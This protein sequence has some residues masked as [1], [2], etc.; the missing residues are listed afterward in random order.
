MIDDSQNPE[1]SADRFVCAERL[2][3]RMLPDE[4]RYTEVGENFRYYLTWREKLFAGFIVINGALAIAFTWV[5]DRYPTLTFLLPIGGMLL[6]VLFQLLDARNSEL[7]NACVA[8]GAELENPGTGVYTKLNVDSKTI[9]HSRIIEVAV[10]VWAAAL[11][12]ATVIL[13]MR[14]R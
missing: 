12:A 13:F 4:N 10:W 9:P 14:A 8:A 3:A 7:F 1:R 5:N 2:Q 6:S 11:G